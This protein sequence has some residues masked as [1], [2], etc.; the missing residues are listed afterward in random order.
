MLTSHVKHTIKKNSNNNQ[1]KYFRLTNNDQGRHISLRQAE[2]L[3]ASQIPGVVVNY[4]V[5]HIPEKQHSIYASKVHL[6]FPISGYETVLHLDHN[7]PAVAPKCEGK[8][9]NL[10]VNPKLT[11]RD[12]VKQ[13]HA[14]VKTMSKQGELTQ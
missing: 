4:D 3:R 8:K 11:L 9:I 7:F 6:Q 2:M 13:I 14:Q 10:D 1:R 12:Y 5:S